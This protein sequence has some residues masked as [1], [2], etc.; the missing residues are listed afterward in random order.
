MGEVWE[1]GRRVPSVLR[2]AWPQGTWDNGLCS[3]HCGWRQTGIQVSFLLS[4]DTLTINQ[5]G[6]NKKTLNHGIC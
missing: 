5:A 6:K 2:V 4:A 3:Q 1:N